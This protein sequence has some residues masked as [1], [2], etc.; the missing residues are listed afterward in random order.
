MNCPRCQAELAEVEPNPRWYRHWLCTDCE[1]AWHL[2]GPILV[3]GRER[4]KEQEA[5]N[6]LAD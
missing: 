2:S 4:N 5:L 6:G 3:L 1:S